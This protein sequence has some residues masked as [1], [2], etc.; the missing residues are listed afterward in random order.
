V[1]GPKIVA[2][3]HAVRVGEHKTPTINKSLYRR[4]GSYMDIME[5]YVRRWVSGGSNPAARHGQER[6]SGKKLE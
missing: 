3:R 6:T 4:E 1:E 5:G 2:N